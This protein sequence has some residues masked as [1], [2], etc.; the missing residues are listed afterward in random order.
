MVG[1]VFIGVFGVLT[2][3]GNNLQT[4]ERRRVRETRD[5]PKVDPSRTDTASS[6]ACFEPRFETGPQ[7]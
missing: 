1:A 3:F 7:S 6:V 2:R 4:R 5:R